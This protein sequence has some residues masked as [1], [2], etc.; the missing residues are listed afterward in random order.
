[1]TISLYCHG[2]GTSLQST[3]P[4]CTECGAP[5]D[6]ATVAT[7]PLIHAS[8]STAD[9]QDYSSVTWYRRRWFVLCWFLTITPVAAIIALTGDVF[10]KSRSGEVKKFDVNIKNGFG[11]GTLIWI[12]FVYLNNNPTSYE[13]L[14]VSALFIAIAIYLGLKK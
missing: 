5:Q 10:Y 6:H 11:A 3:A 12:K 13:T 8:V 1:M 2:C 7:A 4:Y 14:G 9:A